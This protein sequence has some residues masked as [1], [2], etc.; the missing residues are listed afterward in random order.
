MTE[1]HKVT[2]S[3]ERLRIE[4]I[5][6][7]LKDGETRLC[8]LNLARVLGDKFVKQED[9]R[10]SSEPYISQVVH[11]NQTSGAFALLAS[12]GFWDV[13]SAKKAIQ[14]VAQMRERHSTDKENLAETIANV[15]L[16]EARMLRTKDNTSIIFLDFE[17]R[18]RI[19]C[20]V[21][22]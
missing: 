13:V 20:K 6:E 15:L 7:P 11:I 12:D 21:D 16:N 9:S 4:G 10:F 18:S 5:G 3:S 14:L 1:D 8:G 19:S 22:S 17:S 2:S